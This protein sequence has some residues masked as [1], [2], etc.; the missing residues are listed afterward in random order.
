[1]LHVRYIDKIFMI[2][3]CTKAELISI[4]SIWSISTRKITYLDLMLH[5]DENNIQRTLYC[6][7][8]DEQVFVH[9]KSKHLRSL[10]NSIPHSHVLR[11]KTIYLTTT[12]Y[13]KNCASII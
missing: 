11:L 7:P 3:K 4:L 12:E 10:K 2:W 6:K 13:D 5:K 8:T 9:A 1:M